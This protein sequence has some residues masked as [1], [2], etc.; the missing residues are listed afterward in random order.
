MVSDNYIR[1]QQLGEDIRAAKMIFEH[2]FGEQTFINVNTWM[3]FAKEV[4]ERLKAKS[5][6]EVLNFLGI[7]N[8]K[9]I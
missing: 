8:E 5:F 3:E 7:V 6:Q 2:R 9:A 1:Q 4:Q